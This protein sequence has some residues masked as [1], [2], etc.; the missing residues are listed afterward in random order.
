MRFVINS[1]LGLF[2]VILISAAP[3]DSSLCMLL[4]SPSD[5]V[6]KVRYFIFISV[7][8]GIK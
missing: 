8:V 4:E 6:A 3:S 1:V 5:Q 2:L 7:I